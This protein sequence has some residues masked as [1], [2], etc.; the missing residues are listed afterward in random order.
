MQTAG[1]VK[2]PSGNLRDPA[3]WVPRHTDP[4]RASLIWKVQQPERRKGLLRN[5]HLLPVALEL[6]ASSKSSCE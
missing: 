3:V 5:L 1:D 2:N 4:S 6:S